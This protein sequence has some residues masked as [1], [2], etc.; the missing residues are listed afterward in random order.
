M[1][2]CEIL[3][4]R[5]EPIKKQMKDAKWEEIIGQANS[6]NIQLNAS[7][8]YAMKFHT[9]N[10]QDSSI[11]DYSLFFVKKENINHYIFKPLCYFKTL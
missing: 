11:F 6:D 9:I 4:E 3:N 2:A 5:L 10:L 7:Y 1:K 8:M